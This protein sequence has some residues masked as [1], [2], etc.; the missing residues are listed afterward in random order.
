MPEKY[1][2]PLWN[3]NFNPLLQIKPFNGSILNH[4]L[5]HSC[6]QNKLFCF[7]FRPDNPERES[8]TQLCCN[9]IFCLAKSRAQTT[10]LLSIITLNAFLP[11]SPSPCLEG[12][13][14]VG[15]SLVI[16]G[17]E[18]LGNVFYLISDIYD[19]IPSS[20]IFNFISENRFEF[21]G[22]K[23]ISFFFHFWE[24]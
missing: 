15:F 7:I 9:I 18:A 4:R 13:C 17:W 10:S 3:P 22:N 12:A 5:L 8:S 6:F 23:E 21:I 2:K 14:K 11:L 19:E 24:R 1:T 16:V 20:T